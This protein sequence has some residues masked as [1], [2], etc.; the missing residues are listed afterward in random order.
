MYY[1]QTHI[2][3]Y[4]NMDIRLALQNFKIKKRY[5]KDT[6]Y[7]SEIQFFNENKV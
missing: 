6:E 3:A 5:K 7:I 4:T 2:P 1:R